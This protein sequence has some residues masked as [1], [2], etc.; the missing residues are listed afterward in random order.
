MSF[1]TAD[2]RERI[3]G[4]RALG[5]KQTRTAVFSVNDCLGARPRSAAGRVES[6][7][8]ESHRGQPAKRQTPGVNSATGMD[9]WRLPKPGAQP[10]V[11]GCWYAELHVSS[12]LF[13]ARTKY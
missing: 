2:L 6:G 4:R 3:R 8:A 1:T 5:Q 13:A 12:I 11:P 7:R 10:A 9:R